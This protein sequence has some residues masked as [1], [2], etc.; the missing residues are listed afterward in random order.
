MNNT[1]LLT[2]YANQARAEGKSPTEA[3]AVAV[4][5]R[6][7]PLLTTSL[8][9]VLA[10]LPLALNDPFWEGLAFALIFGLLSSTILVLLVFPYFYLIASSLGDRVVRLYNKVTKG[11]K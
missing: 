1:I 2:D 4:R 10:L 9:S 7:R 6:L 11:K 8:T 5:E 3:I